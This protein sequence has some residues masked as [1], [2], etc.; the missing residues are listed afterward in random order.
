MR[1]TVEEVIARSDIT[2]QEQLHSQSARSD[3][4]EGDSI[5]KSAGLDEAMR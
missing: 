2:M 5:R 1:W 3:G 4:G